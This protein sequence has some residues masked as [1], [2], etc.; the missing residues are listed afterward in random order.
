VMLCGVRPG[1]MGKS[2]N[3]RFSGGFGSGGVFT[4]LFVILV[5][6]YYCYYCG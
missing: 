1:S 5:N 2:V 4:L 6:Y 3:V